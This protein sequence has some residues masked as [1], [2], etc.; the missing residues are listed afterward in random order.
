MLG[1]YEVEEAS[2]GIYPRGGCCDAEAPFCKI[3]WSKFSQLEVWQ[4]AT[5]V[6]SLD[7]SQV[8]PQFVR[9]RQHL[10]LAF[11]KNIMPDENEVGLLLLRKYAGRHVVKQRAEPDEIET[12]ELGRSRRNSNKG[13]SNWG[14]SNKGQ[15]NCKFVWRQKQVYRRLRVF[16]LTTPWQIASAF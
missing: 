15:S 3:C 13:Q 4:K 12:A 7:D 1:C 11:V 16:L 10:T 6:H 2:I 5:F 14:N 8:S 9:L